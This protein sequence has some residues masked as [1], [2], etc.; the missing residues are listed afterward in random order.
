M[1]KT[2]DFGP[3]AS[4]AGALVAVTLLVLMLVLVEPRPAEAT[5]PGKNGKIAYKGFDGNDYEIFTID[6]GGE[7]RV[8]VTDNTTSDWRPDYSPNGKRIA[9]SG[10]GD[11]VNPPDAPSS[12]DFEIWTIPA[13]GGTPFQ[14]TNNTEPDLTPS[15]HPA[16]GTIAYSGK[17]SPIKSRVDYEIFAIN[18][19]GEPHFRVT[20]STTS[21]FDH[22]TRAFDPD[23]SPSGAVIAYELF[24]EQAS[25]NNYDIGLIYLESE[26]GRGF[27]ITKSTA[28][29]QDPSYHPSGEL[30]A[31]SAW[32]GDDYE[33]FT[34]KFGLGKES[35][36]TLQITDNRTDDVRPDYSPN[37]KR[38]AFERFDGNDNEIFTMNVDG[39]GLDQVTDNSTDDGDPSWGRKTFLG[40]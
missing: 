9:Y 40:R 14:V 2:K 25:P 33:I 27:S 23:W 34:Y 10:T 12:K 5:F 18:A 20:Y 29:E 8:Q 15:Y 7:N 26:S 4:A 3:L 39:T 36:N 28:D 30:F 17:L 21:P 11:R 16:G 22:D 31:Y 35:E 37:G 6:P 24:D 38:I 32:D 13:T 19:A 1:A